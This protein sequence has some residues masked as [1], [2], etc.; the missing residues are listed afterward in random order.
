MNKRL[1]YLAEGTVI[2]VALSISGCGKY[3]DIAPDMRTD[4]D[5]PEKVGELL[6]TAYPQANYIPFT[7]ILSDNAGDK[8]TGNAPVV[9]SAPYHFQDVSDIHQDSPTYYW[10]A[11]YTAIAAANHALQAIERNGNTEAYQPYKGEALVARAYAHFMLA[12]LFAQPYEEHAAANL[13]GIPYVTEVEDVVIKRYE[14]RTVAYVYDQIEKD[15]LEGLSLLDDGVYISPKFHFTTAAAHAFASR[16]YLFKRAYAKALEHANAVFGEGS[17]ASNLRPV[18][19]EAYRSLQYLELAAHYTRADNPANIL[20]V[21]VPT[22]WGR[23]YPNYRYGFTVAT[24]NEVF[25][26]NVTGGV[27]GYGVYGSDMT[28]NIPKFREHFVRQSL[29]AE[30]GIPYNMVPLFT[31]EEVLFNRAEAKAMM[32]DFV[33]ALAD[34][35][36]YAATRMGYDYQNPVYMPDLHKITRDKLLGF[37]RTFSM[38]EALVKCILDFKRVNFLHEGQRWFDIVRHNLGVVHRTADNRILTL[39]PNDPMR[40][41]QIPQEAQSAGVELNPR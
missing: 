25:G 40:I 11:S 33:G 20:L 29:H 23:S 4:L 12:V 18:N 7:E 26:A 10:N 6:A 34:L 19:S 13:P 38:E 17:F 37:Y 24:W 32:G 14:R 27:W 3:L 8:G 36:D 28:L 16:Y 15:L 9:N 21:E 2:C 30:T 39:G 1:L 35:N 31:A 41:A 5:S 22:L